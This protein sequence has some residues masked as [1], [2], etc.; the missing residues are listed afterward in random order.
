MLENNNQTSNS[1]LEYLQN[2]DIIPQ[3]LIYQNK[4]VKLFPAR[5]KKGLFK[6][7]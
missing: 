7:F 1:I 6:S 3:D 5:T 4:K 2:P